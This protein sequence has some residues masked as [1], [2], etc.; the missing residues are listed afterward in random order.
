MF[1]TQYFK[2]LSLDP[3][4][5]EACLIGEKGIIASYNVIASSFHSASIFNSEERVTLTKVAK[6]LNNAL[7]TCFTVCFNA[8]I[9]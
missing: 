1:V 9:D 5:K 8:K 4:S 7:T 3:V 2:V 6:L